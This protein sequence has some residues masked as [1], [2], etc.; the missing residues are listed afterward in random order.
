MPFDPSS[1]TDLVAMSVAVFGSGGA[2]AVLTAA[3]GYLRDRRKDRE[4]A[5]HEKEL[6]AQIHQQ[7]RES[8]D[9]LSRRLDRVEK[10]NADCQKTSADLREK[11]GR[12][13]A[14]I[15]RLENG[16]KGKHL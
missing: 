2:G 13:A 5:A 8:I 12:M 15:E 4:S 6:L 10:E 16:T 14:V 9:W 3:M 7:Y 11:M 1:T